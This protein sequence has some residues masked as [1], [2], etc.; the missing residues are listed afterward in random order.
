MYAQCLKL[1]DYLENS[2]TYGKNIL[3]MKY[4]SFLPATFL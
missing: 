4:V 2:K 1:L 3:N